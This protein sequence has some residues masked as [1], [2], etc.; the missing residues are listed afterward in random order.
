[1]TT[2]PH[3]D[4]TS[5]QPLTLRTDLSILVAEDDEFMRDLVEELLLEMGVSAVLSARAARATLAILDAA[6]TAP[7]V[8]LFD[9]TMTGMHGIELLR[10]LADREF[11]GGLIVMSG[12]K[13]ELLTLVE[14]LA[15]A[16]GLNLMA[17]LRKPLEPD[18]LRAVLAKV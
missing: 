7:H 10:Q 12:S 18:L 16:Q 4:L 15:L 3:T 13:G 8:V 2:D 17:V 14:D 11:A 6:D 1:M 5:D 9:L